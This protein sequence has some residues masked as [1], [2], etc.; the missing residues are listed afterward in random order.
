MSEPLKEYFLIVGLKGMDTSLMSTATS[1]YLAL[2]TSRHPFGFLLKDEPSYYAWTDNPSAAIL[3]YD[4]V[5]AERTII[6]LQG[7]DS[8]EGGP[9]VIL[10]I[11][12]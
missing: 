5:S 6:K 1:G 8:I 2:A 9:F 4:H 12:L 11:Y 3:F 10:P 7:T